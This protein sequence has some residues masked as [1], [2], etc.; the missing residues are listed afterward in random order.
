MN[1][2][3]TDQIEIQFFFPNLYFIP[4]ILNNNFESLYA[5]IDQV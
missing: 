2:V 5:K 1:I 4:P 3:G